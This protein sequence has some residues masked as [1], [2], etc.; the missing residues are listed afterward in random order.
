MK[1]YLTGEISDLIG[2]IEALAEDLDIELRDDGKRIEVSRCDAGYTAVSCGQCAR[3]SYN[4]KNDFFRALALTVDTLRREKPIDIA[5]SP[6]F[7][8]CGVMLDAS[9]NAVPKLETVKRIIRYMSRM[10]LNRLMLYTEDTYE[11][12]KYPYF[13]YMRGR[14]TEAEL[15]EIDEYSD[16]LGIEAVPCIQTLAHLERTLRWPVYSDI[17]DIGGILLTDEEKTYEFIEEMIKTVRRCFKTDKIHI[18]MDEAHLVGL[19]KYLDKHGYQNRFDILGRHL[20]R[21]VEIA[22][23]YN[24]S[25]MMWSDMFFRLCTSDGDYYG[26][27]LKFPDG[28]EEKIPKNIS[29]VYW[30]YYHTSESEYDAM[31]SGHQKLGC[32]TIFAGGV[33]TWLD[34]SANYEHTFNTTIPALNVCKARGIKNVFATMW[35]D[36]G[37]ECDVT[38]SLY[39]MQ[40]YAEYNYEGGHDRK[41]LDERFRACCGLSAEA[42]WLFDTEIFEGAD[43]YMAEISPLS[44]QLLYQ[45]PMYGL[46]DKNASLVNIKKHYEDLFEKLKTV[47]YPD[48][49]SELFDCHK[50]FVKT[51]CSKCDTGLRLKTAYDADDRAELAAVA[52]DMLEC[53]K[54]FKLLYEKRKL[55]WYKNNKPFGF[56]RVGG[57]LVRAAATLE[58]ASERV[59]DYISGRVERLDELEQERLWRDRPNILFAREFGSN[60]IME[61]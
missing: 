15:K 22:S 13:G 40:L 11:I 59:R 4:R 58:L 3:I 56:D 17:T 33:W 20:G 27:D 53:A 6:L 10:G 49:F 23:K 25:P 12:E 50:Q 54:D 35:G 24:Y 26:T 2:G 34:P 14:Y 48:S 57:R 18:G 43:E 37:A 28:L 9:R 7:D 52:L 42:F 16:M 1:I 41:L 8:S 21:V 51:L 60:G 46:F 30:D 5:E 55:L 45:N 19:G 29:Q 31:V 38:Q 39:G 44:K 36:D 47:E 32:E 61:V